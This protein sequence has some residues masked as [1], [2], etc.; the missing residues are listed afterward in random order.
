MS[1]DTNLK[2]DGARLWQSLM[3]IGEIGKTEK[4]GCKRLALS[5][6][7]RQARD[8]FIQWAK[9]AGCTIKVDRMGNIFARRAGRNDSLPPIMTGSHLDTV[10]TG[11]KFDGILGVMAGLEVM[12]TLHDHD[13]VTEAPIELTVFTNEE[14]SRFAPAM[15][16]SGV[17]SGVF[18]LDYG[19]SRADRDGK[20]IG[21]ELKRIGYDG[22]EEVG[23]RPVGAFFE[24]HI[25][26]GPILEDN[27]RSVG[28]VSGVQSIKWFEA[29][30]AGAEC[31]AGTTPMASRRDAL[32][33]AAEVVAAVE[34]IAWEHAP[35]GRGT[36]GLLEASPNGRNVVT[37]SVFM[38]IDLRHP[39]DAVLAEMQAKL[40]TAFDAAATRR[41]LDASLSCIWESPALHFDA[42][43]VGAVRRAAE[44]GGHAF[45][46]VVSGA[47]HDAVYMSKVAPT[48]MIF[49]PCEKGISHNELESATP[50]DCAAGCDVLLRA[51]VE[52]ANAAAA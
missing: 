27:A 29:T 15:V 21:E 43:C 45:M 3:D 9:D 32:V 30:L 10:P 19:L 5:D 51:M 52:R 17:F 38:T 46:E 50:E 4:G 7:D 40:Q 12:R 2:I 42:D 25:E 1:S 6:L 14:G 8:L 24:V 26:Q 41:A 49:I 18:S 48:A 28:V 33:A 13:Y 37:G 36:V 39:Q 16:S 35:D 34:R 44:A 31:H 20:T 23:G 11:G 22:P 47:G